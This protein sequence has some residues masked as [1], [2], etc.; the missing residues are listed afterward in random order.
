M[1]ALGVQHVDYFSLDVEDA[2][3][4]ILKTIDGTRLRIDFLTIEFYI[5]NESQTTADKL[6]KIRQ[7]FNG[8]KMNREVA[9]RSR[10]RF[11]TYP[12]IKQESQI[13]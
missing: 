8:T 11:R 9:L 3:L 13:I 1:A 12:A 10:C 6:T 4:D 7:L 5:G 2:E